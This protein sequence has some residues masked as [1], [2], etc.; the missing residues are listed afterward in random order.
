MRAGKL[1]SLALAAAATL[2]LALPGG[3]MAQGYRLNPLDTLEVSAA[4]WDASRGEMKPLQWF[5]GEYHVDNDGEV[6]LPVTSL[7]PLGG[8]TR[9]EAAEAVRKALSQTLGIVDGLHLSLR[10]SEHGPIFVTGAVENPGQYEYQP[11]L[12]ALQAVALA[13]GLRRAQTLYSRTDRDSARALGD[14]ELLTVERH[15][16]LAKLARL[17]AEADDR[18]TIDTPADL[19]GVP[20]ADGL[21]DVEQEILKARRDE[22]RAALTAISELKELLHQRIAKLG[23][24]KEV[25]EKILVDTRAE[26]DSIA[27]LVK[28]GLSRQSQAN[29]VARTLAEEEARVLALETT[30]LT[31]QQQLSEAERERLDLIGDRRVDIITRLQETRTELNGLDVRLRT[32]AALYSEAARFGSEI[33]AMEERTAG[34]SPTLMVVRRKPDGT[35]TSDV[36]TAQTELKPGDVLQVVAPELGG[37]TPELPTADAKAGG[38]AAPLYPAA[39]SADTTN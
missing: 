32:A 15:R 27:T 34:L 2:A 21:L 16:A 24:E 5:S 26:R 30:I 36:A 9:K 14:H 1:A 39:Y 22:H 29:E 20:M 6:D 25:R 19:E 37:S 4:I 3:A 18:D 28:R 7:P 35:T 11:G 8:M 33:S 12:V 31:A 17:E 13:G 38:A 10:V 23:Q